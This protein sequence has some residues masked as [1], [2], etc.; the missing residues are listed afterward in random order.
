M[1]RS[2]KTAL[3]VVV[4][5]GPGCH[6]SDM[7]DADVGSSGTEVGTTD[8]DGEPTGE[9]E[10]EPVAGLMPLRRLTRVEYDNTV[11][12]LLGDTTRPAQN[13]PG[14]GEGSAGFASPGLVG[15]TDVKRIME[16]AE[17]LAAEAL[18]DLPALLACSPAVDGEDTCARRFIVEVGGRAYRRPLHE[19][20]VEALLD[21]YDLARAELAQDFPGGLR[22]VLQAMLQ[23][24]QFLYRWELG[25]TEPDRD[26]ALVRLNGHEVASRLSYFLWSSMPDE[27]LFA[28]AAAGELDTPARVEA[29]ARRMLADPRARDTIENF[30]RQWLHLENLPAAFKSPEL[31]PGFDDALKQSMLAETLAFVD[32]VIR[33]GDGRVETLLTAT[34]SFVDERLAGLYGVDG[35]VGPE[36]RGPVELDP[37]QRI[38]LLTHAS[39]L[40]LGANAYDSDP[41]RRGK[42]VRERLVSCEKLP[43]PPNNIPE[44]EPPDPNKPARERYEQHSKEEPCRSCHVLTDPIGFGLQHFD[45]IGQYRLMEGVHPI[46]ASGTVQGLDGA[47]VAFDGFIELAHV[48]ADSEAVRKCVARQLFRFGFA[49]REALAD[50]P[51]IDAAYA[52]SVAADDNLREYIVALTTTP[53]FRYR[54][55]AEG[56]VLP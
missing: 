30:T 49:R 2:L 25:E 37:T 44:L 15:S 38:G 14:E 53:S 45:A 34:Y 4:G 46:D 52:T 51:S 56:E 19:L 28:A 16:A 11:R 54:M 10:E 22:V 24:P 47:N 27:P 3:L 50:I 21:L 18:T 36:L 8:P 5:A 9:P 35:V 43:P 1:R 20:E 33:A 48:L 26:G 55:P 39:V 7:D 42:L 29:Q 32:H 23:S 17:A 31:F 13:F 40:T 6:S 12:D 41:I